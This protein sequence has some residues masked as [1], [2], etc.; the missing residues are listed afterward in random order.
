VCLLQIALCSVPMATIRLKTAFLVCFNVAILIV[1]LRKAFHDCR[2]LI[3]V[4]SGDMSRLPI[5]STEET[6]YVMHGEGDFADDDENLLNYI[7]S[8]M[9]QQ[10][11]GGRHL[12]SEPSTMHFS[13]LGGSKFIDKLLKQR[14]NGFFVECGAYRGEELSETLFF[15]KERNWTGILIE[16]HPDFHHDILTKNRHAI[17]LRGCLSSTRRPGVLK[18]KLNSKGSGLTSFNKNV[19]ADD[20]TVPETD[21]Q[22]FSLNSIMAAIGVNHIDFMVLDVEGSEIPVLRTI[23]WARLSVDVFSIEYMLPRN[24]VNKLQTIRQFFNATG[25]YHEVGK[26]PLGAKDRSGQDVIFMRF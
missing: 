12:V 23:D 1:V 22:C 16:A 19:N 7:R 11:P 15:E 21:V 6:L 3:V 4:S 10:G 13:Q 26:L 14:R 18:F 20:K 9:S 25:H 24:S 2:S 8:M 5:R 17:V